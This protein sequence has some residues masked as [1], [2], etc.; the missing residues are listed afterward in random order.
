[1]AKDIKP[2]VRVPHSV[3]KGEVFEVKCLV[4]HDMETGQRKDKATG[5]IIPRDILN[6]LVVTY[7]GKEV[8]KAKWAP[9]VSANPY[10]SFYV[11]ATDSGPMSFTWTEDGGQTYEKTVQ[12]TVAA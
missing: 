3:K 8:L 9:A 11:V 7:G 6:T 2:R 12:V 10:T 4:T 1:M 5:K